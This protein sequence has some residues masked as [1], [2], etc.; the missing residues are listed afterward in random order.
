MDEFEGQRLMYYL[1]DFKS[2]I[3]LK[4]ETMRYTETYILS[5][6]GDVDKV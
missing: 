4:S 1:A 6:L 3:L 2:A 5:H